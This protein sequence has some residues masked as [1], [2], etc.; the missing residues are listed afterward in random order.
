MTSLGETV[1]VV[2][3]GARTVLGM[4]APSS[5]A[6][7][8]AGVSM[9]TEH[10]FLFD[11]DGDAFLVAQTTYLEIDLRGAARLAELAGPAASEALAS[12]A[13]WTTGRSTVPIF[14]GL[15][16]ARP[17]RPQD[18]PTVVAE[19]VR[20][21]VTQA[22]LRPRTVEIVETGHSAGA[23]AVQAAWEAVR[24]G[25]AEVAL[26][27]GVDSYLE[28]ETM[29]WLEENE[30]VHGAGANSWG[31]IPGEAAGFVLLSTARA[32]E[33]LDSSV[34]LELVTTTTTRETKLI[35]SDAVCIGEGLTSLF[36]SLAKGSDSSVRMDHLVCDMNGEPYRAEE[37]GF[38]VVRAGQLFRSPSEFATP[39]SCWGDV[40]AASGPLFLA[41]SDASVRRGYAAG[42]LTMAFTSSESGERCGFV[43]RAQSPQGS[44]IIGQTERW[45]VGAGEGR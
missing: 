23:M 39:A 37:F 25:T 27:G 24:S 8:R 21:E 44:R 45:A 1:V 42:P 3:V 30:Q 33:R 7:V 36:R 31:F 15:P 29:V 34:A 14:L 43:A 4:T 6:A 13:A 18:A 35:K 32:A 38:A 20:A 19:R 41:L 22:Q 40:G 10:P 16:S 17:G 11:A 5:A 9:F 2:G 28:T 12:F 26:A